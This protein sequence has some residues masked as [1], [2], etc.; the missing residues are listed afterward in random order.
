M[1]GVGGKSGAL[2][3]W[4]VDCSVL[5]GTIKSALPTIAVASNSRAGRAR[6]G[7]LRDRHDARPR[8]AAIRAPGWERPARQPKAACQ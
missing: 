6:D 4:S 8:L 5:P 3:I 1:A 7:S 2:S